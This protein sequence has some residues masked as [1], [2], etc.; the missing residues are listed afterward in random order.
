MSRTSRAAL[1]IA[2]LGLVVPSLAA[3]SPPPAS[4]TP[5]RPEVLGGP[6]AVAELDDR[7]PRVAR[8]HG[9]TSTRLRA[10]LRTDDTLFVDDSER[11]LYVRPAAPP[12]SRNRVQD[13]EAVAT[14]ADSFGLHS[15]PGAQRTIYLDFDGHQL[16]DGTAWAPQG[17]FAPPYNAE[18]SGSTFTAH[19]LAVVQSVWA[20]V[21]EDYAPFDVDVT[22]EDPGLAAIRRSNSADQVYGT[23]VVITDEATTCGCGG[24]AYLGVFDSTGTTHDYYQPAWV[25]T[26]GV[27]HGAHNIAEA[28][29]HEAGHNLG[30]NHDGTS[31]QG[32][33]AGH[34]AWA[35]I[36]GVGYDEPITHWSRGEYA[37][38]NNGED[39]WAV[40][41]S[42][43]APS[44][45]DD[46]GDHTAPTSLGSADTVDTSGLI[47]PRYAT[48]DDDDV[49]AFTFTAGAGPV[50]LR[51]DPAETSPNLDIA[52]TL[53]DASGVVVASDDPVSNQ[54]SGD[55]ASGMAAAL[56]VTLAG[57]TYT[58][59]VDGVGARNPLTTGYS[60]Y[61]SVGPYTLT[62][63][64]Q[65]SDGG[66]PANLAP[67]ASA[68]ATPTSGTAPLDVALSSAGSADPDGS[69]VSRT[70][71]FGD[72]SSSTQA[73]P[74]HTYDTGTWTA[75]LTVV[76]DA[77]AS[78]TDTVT[79]T[80]SAVTTG[81]PPA[82]SE[83][84]ATEA[85][86]RL[87]TISWTDNADD[88]DGFTVEVQK[89]RGRSRWTSQGSVQVG[90]DTTS[91][92]TSVARGTHRFLVRAV[93]DGG[94]SAPATSNSIRLR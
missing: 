91:V 50:T 26:L 53:R 27:G 13:A 67:R 58:I 51:A 92:T 44:L 66:P 80:A 5:G 10:L 59:E 64:W 55:V 56:D 83:A 61:G 22:T 25:Y 8:A 18:G 68:S 1:V 63:A 7:L 57:G 70:W 43:G 29:S 82:P 11:L 41:V 54:V 38:A 79:V 23:R 21:A 16:P 20:R 69:I 9:L 86:R 17:Y 42:N 3:A 12:A 47:T 31:T 33:Y 15:R 14:L 24:V 49:D 76:D 52:L 93:N 35:P 39:D 45:P 78:A 85:G 60:D 65:P 2:A 90:P 4:P 6:A 73:N 34:G 89:R 77:G 81:P 40:M 28:A 94:A 37:G 74:S 84:T 72:G 30:L 19:E 88:E 75:T 32:Y 62:G 46:H 36:M 87:V 71:D 48:D